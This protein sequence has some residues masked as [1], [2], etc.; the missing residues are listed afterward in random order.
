[1]EDPLHNYEY[2]PMSGHPEF[3]KA[4]A[5]LLFGEDSPALRQNRVASVQTISGTGA[6]YLGALF[7]HKYYRFNGDR[8]AYVSDPTWGERCLFPEKPQ[9]H[10][11]HHSP[12]LKVNHHP[13]FNG[14]GLELDTYPYYNHVTNRLDFTRLLTAFHNAPSGSVM[15][16]HACAH[17]PTG[18]DP[19]RDQWSAI[20]DVMLEKGHFAFFDCAY[21]GFASGDLDEDAWAVREFARRGVPMLV[22]Q[23]G[24]I[25]RSLC[26]FSLQPSLFR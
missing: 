13:I 22:C 17:N 6:N 10:T 25:E 3:T 16:L 4:A 8:K 1:V 14:V 5:V 18:V 24:V 19:T 23:V 2:L 15:V 26:S 12:C 9:T 7:T 21:Q 11:H 20:A